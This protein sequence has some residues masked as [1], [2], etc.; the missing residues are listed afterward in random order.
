MAN[1]FGDWWIAEKEKA[2]FMLTGKTRHLHTSNKL[3]P[4]ILLDCINLL[5]VYVDGI[6]NNKSTALWRD[7][8]WLFVKLMSSLFNL[9]TEL[10]LIKERVF[11]R[12]VTQRNNYNLTETLLIFVS[13]TLFQFYSSCELTDWIYRVLPTT[14][15]YTKISKIFCIIL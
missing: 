10:Y 15:F 13:L 4:F 9:V 14:Y 1:L 3:L 8:W 6:R 2:F 12:C 11:V 5:K 7:V